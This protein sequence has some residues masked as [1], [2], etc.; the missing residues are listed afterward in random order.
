MTVLPVVAREL[1]VASRRRWSY[2]GRTVSAFLALLAVVWLLLMER[3]M[4]LN[5]LGPMVF[6]FTS[7]LAAVFAV[8]AGAM[9][10]ADALAQE[11][12][13]GTL[14]LLFLTDLKGYDVLFGKMAASSLGALFHMA[15]CLPVMGLSILMGGVSA[16]EYMRMVALLLGGLVCSLSLGMLASTWTADSKR[17]GAFALGL[18]IALCGLVPAVGGIVYWLAWRMGMDSQE[19]EVFVQRQ[20]LC[21]TPVVGFVHVFD[22]EYGARP[23]MYWRPIAMVGG[24]TIAALSLSAWRLPRIW[25]EKEAR[26]NLGWKQ[27]LERWRWPTVEARARWRTGLLESSPMV[28]LT[29][30]HW[31]GAVGFWVGLGLLAVIYAVFAMEIG[32]DWFESPICVMTSLLLHGFV[33][34]RIAA[35]SP[36]QF[37]EDRRNGGMELL[38][39]TPLTIE[40]IV[41]GR[42]KALG[43]LFTKPVVAILLADLL[44][45]VAGLKDAGSDA[46]EYVLFWVSHMALLVMDAYAMAWVGMWIGARVKGNR[47]TIHVLLRVLVLPWLIVVGGMTFIG[48]L[49]IGARSVGGPD[50]GFKTVLVLWTLLCVVNN[51]FWISKCRG[52]LLAGLRELGR[53][54]PGEKKS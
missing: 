3:G 44:L 29:C 8:L 25:Q 51:A 23:W 54:R 24:V 27:R 13:E 37:H 17:A 52:Q 32:N 38:L 21:F 11:R 47:T 2:W 4:V 45:L 10:S 50:F 36:R 41:R 18:G 42:L 53:T 16:N 49:S 48:I 5:R 28:W 6:G 26:G 15:A 33:K 35:E 12:R 1:R 43:Q 46:D 9:Y 31:L 30:R 40:E 14:G 7:F 39:S 22:S 34:L 19:L 20:F